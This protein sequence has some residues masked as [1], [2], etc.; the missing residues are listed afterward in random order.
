MKKKKFNI[1]EK[2]CLLKIVFLFFTAG[3]LTIGISGCVKTD[4]CDCTNIMTGTWNYLEKPQYID[5][6]IVGRTK[7]VAIFVT[8][9]GSS[10]YFTTPVPLRYQSKEPIKVALCAEIIKAL[11]LN[12]VDEPTAYQL[13]CI[14][15]EEE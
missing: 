9:G 10:I 13:T 4:S 12:T 5:L 1:K 7:I 14:E 15:K 11:R 6:Y 8:D 2:K 3:L